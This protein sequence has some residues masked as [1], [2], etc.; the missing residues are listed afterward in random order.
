M[1]EPRFTFRF[2][3]SVS[4]EM[5]FDPYPSKDCMMRAVSLGQEQYKDKYPMFIMQCVGIRDRIGNLIYEGDICTFENSEEIKC[6]TTRNTHVV[7]WCMHCGG[8]NIADNNYD[9]HE[10]CVVVG[11]VFQRPKMT[12]KAVLTK[13]QRRNL[14]LDKRFTKEIVE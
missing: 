7:T 12:R 11:N 2:W 10:D 6:Y 4:K 1:I 8:F 5:F 14:V 3:D 9:M 13:D